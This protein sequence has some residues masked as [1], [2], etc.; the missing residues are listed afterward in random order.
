MTKPISVEQFLEKSKTLPI[1]DVRSPGEFERGHIVEAVNIPL[2]ENHE[3][4]EVGTRYKKVG[5]E[6]AFLLGLDIVG[7][8][9]SG[10]VKKS[11]KVA[12]NG[13]VLVHCWR[14]GMRSGSFATLLASAGMQVYTLIGGYKRYRTY[15]LEKLSQPFDLIVLGGK[16]GSGKT[17]ILYEL[18][19]KGEQIIDLEGLAH[20]KGSSFGMIGQKPQPTTEQFENE[21]FTH[22][23][24][25]DPSRRIWIEDESRNI[26]C[27]NVPDP[28][29][30]LMRTSRV[31][32]ID[33]SKEIRIK[34][35]VQEY[36]QFS[37]NDLK[38]ATDR[39]LK[40]LGGQNHKAAV[41]ALEKSDF[42]LGVDIALNYYDKTYLH[43]LSKREPSKVTTISIT[44]N[45]PSVAAQ[46]LIDSF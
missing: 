30:Q 38:A 40:H 31:A 45:N 7:P 8:K 44:E 22:V 23:S 25:L 9:L 37:T 28:L 26:G 10:F 11:R 39:I 41:D 3:R 19:K 34:R 27:C 5:K 20:H 14:G 17:E 16:T 33:V 21:L 42:E 29:W 15:A 36:A 24:Q 35:L 12:P 4:A 13:E 1:I 43:G 32:F 6:S 46:L 18:A 2:F